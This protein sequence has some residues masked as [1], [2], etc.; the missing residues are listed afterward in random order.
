MRKRFRLDQMARRVGA[1]AEPGAARRD[2]RRVRASRASAAA[3]RLRP[4]SMCASRWSST[5][6]R[7]SSARVRLSMS[8]PCSASRASSKVR[9][10][11]WSATT[12]M[13]PH[14]R[15]H[16]AAD[17]HIARAEHDGPHAL[18]HFRP[19]DDVGDRA[20]VLDG[21]EHHALG[22]ARPLP[23]GDQAG[24]LTRV[25]LA[26]SR[27]ASLRRMPRAARSARR[28]CA[29]CARKESRRKR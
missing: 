6:R 18:E 26:R 1:C 2:R 11:S 5:G 29:G 8:A 16:A 21:H 3:S 13:T 4:P 15:L 20:F 23:A 17:R 19:H 22:R 10:S 25:L 28:N 24:N 9:S 7:T 27:S 12:W 14:L